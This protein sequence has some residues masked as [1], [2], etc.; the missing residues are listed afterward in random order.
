MLATVARETRKFALRERS[1][2]AMLRRAKLGPS[3]LM[4]LLL[5][6]GGIKQVQAS[7][8]ELTQKLVSGRSART[9]PHRFTIVPSSVSMAPNQTQHFGVTDA[10]GNP[11][12][13][14]WN[15]SGLH[16]AG[17]A[18]GN[19]DADGNYTPPASLSHSLEITLEGVVISDPNFS[20]MTRVEIVPGAAPVPNSVPASGVQ[21]SGVQV[22]DTKPASATPLVERVS[23]TPNY[24]V[25]ANQR[26]NQAVAP[27]P[28]IANSSVRQSAPAPTP[29]VIAAAPKVEAHAP[30][31]VT[32]GLLPLPSAVA[33]T[34]DVKPSSNSARQQMPP[35]PD[36]VAAAPVVKGKRRHSDEGMILLDLPSNVS[37]LTVP[38][39]SESTTPG[40]A[41]PSKVVASSS[42]PVTS[43]SSATARMADKIAAPATTTT[44]ATHNQ[45]ADLRPLPSP[46]NAAQIAKAPPVSTLSPVQPTVQPTVSF[47]VAPAAPSTTIATL[48]AET[49][50]APASVVNIP[51]PAQ[52][53]VR[54]PTSATVVAPVAPRQMASIGI[55]NTNPQMPAIVQ[56][57]PSVSHVSGTTTSGTNP[58]ATI[59]ATNTSTATI[60][61]MPA[62]TVVTYRDGEL[63]IDA[64]NTTL[65]EVLKLVAKKMGAVIDVPPGSGEE[66]IV[67]HV[68]P[69]HPND[70]L[71]QLLN[72]SHFNF[73]I[74]NSAI[75]PNEPAEVLLSMQGTDTSTPL[76]APTPAL[77]P[78]TSA[79]WTPPDPTLKP[80]PLPP[81]YDPSLAP[82]PNRE[83]LTP[84]AI[85]ELMRAKAK[86][87]RERAMQQAGVQPDNSQPPPPPPPAPQQ[88][89]EQ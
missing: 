9:I 36:A 64:E 45:V 32:T 75:H 39:K 55:T 51:V 87:L 76:G 18:C 25:A 62:G 17:L 22:S 54:P 19:I 85:S 21:V 73:I 27:A 84:D 13:V 48:K 4:F 11:V 52:P 31:A 77:A 33:A 65:A 89:Q 46:A 44:A 59:P 66:R 82:P 74:V 42:A 71:T 56:T 8:P 67:E 29:N 72:G 7:T 3:F 57:A 80:L 12:A 5:F 53:E 63:R 88:T 40:Q 28:A 16:C 58:S 6:S 2:F 83:S 24:S 79:F 47:A 43:S 38:K 10:Q 86:E 70:V 14:H 68:G 81:Q 61:S 34:P 37:N 23:A 78:T 50:P 49:K 60:S 30:T 26:E 20:V 35:V 41:A 69:G 15:I 1:F